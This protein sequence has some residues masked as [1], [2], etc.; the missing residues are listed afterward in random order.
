M[1]FLDFDGVLHPS[2][3][4]AGQSLPFEW[5]P[6]LARLLDPFPDVGVVV[7][8]TW[9][10][11]FSLDYIQDFLESLGDRFIDVAPPGEKAQAIQQFLRE[12]P[13]VGR[14][15]ILDDEPEQFKGIIAGDVL[16]VACEPRRG[17]SCEQPQLKVLTWLQART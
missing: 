11:Q 14:A 12:H 17:I 9:R 10:E 7:H 1:L 6:A 3:T 5:L 4:P 13:E 2:G 15:L 8:S 16:V